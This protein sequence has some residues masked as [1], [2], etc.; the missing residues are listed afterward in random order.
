MKLSNNGLMMIEGFEGLILEAYLDAGGTCTIGYGHTGRIDGM[1]IC[2]DMKITTSKAGEL[3]ASDCSCAET[4]VNKYNSIYNFN[5]NQFD[6]LVSFA[7]NIG[8]IKQLTQNGTRTCNQIQ[9]HM[10]EYNHCAG[11]VCRGLTQRRRKEQLLFNTDAPSVTNKTNE[12]VAKEVIQGKWGNGNNR[13]VKLAAYGY[14]YF[15]IQS[16]V[17]KLLKK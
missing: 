12:D 9:E 16:I 10:P 4:E 14:D 8:S 3:L 5:Q 15:T 2:L 13:R 11:K 6:A 1:K 17:N 7:F